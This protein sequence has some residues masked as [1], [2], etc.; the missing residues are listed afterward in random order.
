[1][2]HSDSQSSLSSTES[3]DGLRVAVHTGQPLP[4]TWLPHVSL[5]AR[6]R[7]T[8]PILAELDTDLTRLPILYELQVHEDWLSRPR[9]LPRSK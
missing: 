9:R 1:M 5:D 8:W 7:A 6:T 4:N 3:T 2:Y